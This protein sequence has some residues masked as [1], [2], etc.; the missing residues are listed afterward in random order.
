MNCDRRDCNNHLLLTD[1]RID[2]NRI[3]S[4][5]VVEFKSSSIANARINFNTWLTRFR[6]FMKTSK[7]SKFR[8]TV[9]DFLEKY[10]EDLY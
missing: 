5:C 7:K 9:N 3:C 10:R 1:F 4:S 8:I 2:D 6:K